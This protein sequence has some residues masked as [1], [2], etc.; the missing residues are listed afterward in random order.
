MG[1][2][3]ILIIQNTMVTFKIDSSI[4]FPQCIPQ[5]E[6]CCFLE[7]IGKV[8]I[9]VMLNT[10]VIFETDEFDICHFYWRN[11]VPKFG[12]C[13]ILMKIRELTISVMLNTMLIFR[14]DDSDIRQ[15]YWSNYASKFQSCCILRRKVRWLFYHAKQIDSNIQ[16]W[17]IW[18][19]SLLLP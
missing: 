4:L 8:T 16:H 5:F 18:H 3:I 13:Y 12:N 7:K 14:I 17:W 15:Y 11:L 6:N 10:M 1:K 9:S 19:W 2:V